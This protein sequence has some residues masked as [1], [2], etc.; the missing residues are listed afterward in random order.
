MVK[1]Y[2]NSCMHLAMPLDTGEVE[3]GILTCLH[4]G[5]KYNLETGEC[6]TSP[7]MFLEAYPV[8]RSGDKVLVKLV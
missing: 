6:L 2:R 5:F 4:H 7:A 3:N 1:G 8:K